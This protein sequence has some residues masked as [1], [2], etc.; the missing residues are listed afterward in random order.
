MKNLNTR[1]QKD[2]EKALQTIPINKMIKVIDSLN[3]IEDTYSKK[4]TENQKEKEWDKIESLFR[5]EI[6]KNEESTSKRT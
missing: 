4:L 1:E 6:Q 3:K 2:I 5:K